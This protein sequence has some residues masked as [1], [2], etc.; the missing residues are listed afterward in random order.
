VKEPPSGLTFINA[1]QL[2]TT[3]TNGEA[4]SQYFRDRA[5]PR[6]GQTNHDVQKRHH[7]RKQ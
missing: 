7:S 4:L 6:R 5:R 2:S 3:E 1:S